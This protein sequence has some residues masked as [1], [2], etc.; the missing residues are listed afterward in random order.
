VVVRKS[1]WNC[2]TADSSSPA[3]TTPHHTTHQQIDQEHKKQA[4]SGVVGSCMDK[5]GGEVMHL[6]DL[7]KDLSRLARLDHVRL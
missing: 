6:D 4:L 2:S 3:C 7:C 1:R 5:A